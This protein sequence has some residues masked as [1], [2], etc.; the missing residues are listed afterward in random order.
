M[1]KEK[2]IKLILDELQRAEELHPIWPDDPIHAVAI[3]VEESGEALQSALDIHCN[4]KHASE[5]EK[6]LI[7]TGAMA[8]RCLINLKMKERD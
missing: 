1:S 8:I 4:G 6:E 3:M 5:L 2:A 7:H